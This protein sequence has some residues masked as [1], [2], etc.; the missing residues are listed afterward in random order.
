MS[1]NVY[2]LYGNGQV[3]S[4]EWLDAPQHRDVQVV[5][6]RDPANEGSWTLRHG[7]KGGSECD[8]FR[9]DDD[10]SVVGMDLAG[11]IDYVVNDLGIVKQGKMLSTKQWKQRHREA[12][13]FRSK[14]LGDGPT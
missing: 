2:I 12:I 14:L 10:G 8:F 4:G 13:H 9:L 5:I 11:M 7:A 6:F 1:N 3:F